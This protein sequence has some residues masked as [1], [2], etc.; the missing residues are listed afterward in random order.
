MAFVDLQEDDSNAI[1]ES[2]MNELC[3]LDE[4]CKALGFEPL[5]RMAEILERIRM[6]QYYYGQLIRAE[7]FAEGKYHEG[8]V[9]V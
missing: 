8:H 4:V 9:R 7:Q 3:L 6:L 2:A 5:T 1:W